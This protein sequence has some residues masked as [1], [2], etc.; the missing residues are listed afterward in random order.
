MTTP[1]PEVVLPESVRCRSVTSAMCTPEWTD[2]WLPLFSMTVD[3][4]DDDDNTFDDDDDVDD[5][6]VVLVVDDDDDELVLPDLDVD[7]DVDVSASGADDDIDFFVFFSFTMFTT[8]GTLF[9]EEG[10][11]LQ[12]K[13]ST[14]T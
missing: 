9:M 5:D 10:L 11:T 1:P 6:L 14:G 8:V 3:D 13:T 4:L 12:K 7:D 2:V